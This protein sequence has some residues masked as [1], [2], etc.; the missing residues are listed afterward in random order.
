MF[1]HSKILFLVPLLF[2]TS[3]PT[4]F[5]NFNFLIILVCLLFIHAKHSPTKLYQC[6]YTVLLN[7]HN[8]SINQSIHTYYSF[9]RRSKYYR[10]LGNNYACLQ[11]LVNNAFT[12]KSSYVIAK[13]GERRIKGITMAQWVN[14]LWNNIF[15][16]PPPLPLSCEISG[17]YT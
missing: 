1:S 8:Q 9:S 13:E 15:V 14:C 3:I 17:P 6:T 11:A 16:N 5:L 10:H 2:V 4:Y 12:W 7:N